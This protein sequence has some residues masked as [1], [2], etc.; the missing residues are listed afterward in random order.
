MFDQAYDYEHLPF[1]EQLSSHAAGDREVRSLTVLGASPCGHCGHS[2][3]CQD[4]SSSPLHMAA[5]LGHLTTDSLTARAHG[6][7]WHGLLHFDFHSHFQP[8]LSGLVISTVASR[9]STI[10]HI[11]RYFILFKLRLGVSLYCVL[12]ILL[13][14]LSDIT[15]VTSQTTQ[16]FW[17]D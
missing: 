9:V 11:F 12:W 4:P 17:E 1:S 15:P 2:G 16:M 6:P 10:N 8:T 7:L 13:P 14:D 3:T 5:R